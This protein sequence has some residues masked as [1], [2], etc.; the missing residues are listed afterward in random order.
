MLCGGEIG[1]KEKVSSF[2]VE[3]DCLGFE[4]RIDAQRS[5]HDECLTKDDP[6]IDEIARAQVLDYMEA[7][8][9]SKSKI[10]NLRAQNLDRAR[11]LLKELEWRKKYPT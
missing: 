3:G 11:K 5:F 4:C 8:Q 10:D 9:M 1:E 7:L 6:A 2:H